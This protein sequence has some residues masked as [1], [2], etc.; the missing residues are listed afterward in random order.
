MFILEIHCRS[1][2]ESVIAPKSRK[3]TN[4]KNP[5]PKNREDTISA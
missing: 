4:K 5:S 1:L 2:R 3:K